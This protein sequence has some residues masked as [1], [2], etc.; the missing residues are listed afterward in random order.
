MSKEMGITRYKEIVSFEK[1]ALLKDTR[2]E[3]GQRQ[4]VEI[5]R[6]RI[7]GGSGVMI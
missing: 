4:D 6:G 5:K 1:C 7:F 2:E 3:I